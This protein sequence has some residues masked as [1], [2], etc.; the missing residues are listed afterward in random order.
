VAIFNITNQL[1]QIDTGKTR[2]YLYNQSLSP[3]A[4]YSSIG[5]A[6]V[7]GQRYVGA[8]NPT[9]ANPFGADGIFKLVYY[10]STGNPAPAAAPAPVYWVD[11]TFTS[12]TGV[13]SEGFMGLNGPAGYLMVNTTDLP[14]LNAA[15]LTG[16]TAYPNVQVIIQ[17][18]GVLIG[19][20]SPASIV[21]GDFIFGAA[22]NFT[23][24]RSAAGT[25]PGYQ[26]FGRAMSAVVGGLCN[27]LLDCDI[28]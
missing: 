8:V 25:Y 16:T 5:E 18:A 3:I 15:S 12:V 6:Q 13:E 22:G 20:I 2:T 23:A 28:I 26:P 4:V 21:A 7:P 19:G 10:K 17:V 9:V 14:S 27:I 24:A 1:L 11:N